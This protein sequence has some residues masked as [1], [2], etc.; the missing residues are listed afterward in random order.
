MGIFIAEQ[1]AH[2]RWCMGLNVLNELKDIQCN[3]TSGTQTSRSLGQKLA[4]H[5]AL[6]GSYLKLGNL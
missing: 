6:L 2:F 1:Q 5:V 3:K 4:N